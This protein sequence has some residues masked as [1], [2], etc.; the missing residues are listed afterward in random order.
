MRIVEGTAKIAASPA[1]AT[2][3]DQAWPIW[4][5]IVPLRLSAAAPVPAA[6]AENIAA[7]ALPP[8]L[9]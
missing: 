1:G 2:D 4:S 6:G 9:V 5:G 8:W 7:P 3:I